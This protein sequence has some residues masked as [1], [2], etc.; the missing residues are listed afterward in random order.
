MPAPPPAAA[1]LELPPD[2]T[3]LFDPLMGAGS[4]LGVLLLDRRGLVLAGSMRTEGAT[5]EDLGAIIGAAVDE[6]IR[7][8]EHLSLGAWRSLVL[9]SEAAVLQVAPVTDEAVI[10]MAARHGTPMG[11]ILRAS[12][13]AAALAERYVGAGV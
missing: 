8:V 9:Q 7:T 4:L 3:T 10:I 13:Q 12:A 2:P 5:L 6:A 1:P 11:W